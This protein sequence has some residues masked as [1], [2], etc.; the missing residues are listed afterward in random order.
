MNNQ[1]Q[2]AGYRRDNLAVATV[3][4]ATLA[5]SAAAG[6]VIGWVRPTL[7]VTGADGGLAIVGDGVSSPGFTAVAMV[8]I[9]SLVVAMC[10]VATVWNHTRIRPVI[11]G[12]AAFFGFASEVVTAELAWWTAEKLHPIPATGPPE[13][14]HAHVVAPFSLG[15]GSWFLVPALAAA[16]YWS[17]ALVAGDSKRVRAALGDTPAGA[18]AT[19]AAT[20][21]GSGN[22]ETGHPLP[23]GS[24]GALA[25]NPDHRTAPEGPGRG[26]G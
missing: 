26:S 15:L 14:I 16:F 2:P 1:P 3:L 23:A 7:T 21:T 24:A 13:G 4:V 5:I 17:L 19:A 11:L 22:K 20:T 9:A 25:H 12:W 8:T 18:Q 10:A 6:T